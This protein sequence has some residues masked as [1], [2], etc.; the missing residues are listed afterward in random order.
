MPK[1]GIVN[2]ENLVDSS[3]RVPVSVD[4][5]SAT[6]IQIGAVEIKNAT[7]DTRATVGSNGLHVDVRN[8][9]ETIADD[10]AFTVATSKVAPAGFL[11]DE[12]ATD[13]VDEGDTGA[14]R[15]TL[16]RKVHVVNEFE[17]N[18]IRAS[19]TSLT[20][21]YAFANIAASTTDGAVVAAV[22]SKKI[23]VLGLIVMAGGTA[24]NIT[25]N[26]KP[27]GAGTAKTALFATG[28]NNGFG[29]GFNPVGWFETASGEGLSATTGTGS[30]VGVQVV[31]CE[32]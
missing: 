24:T 1:A 14:A 20:P 16:D 7:D 27:G 11:A 5:F 8:N 13:S 31:Y 25:F 32:V 10:A 3:G 2:I 4:N 29:M 26:T 23:R 17:S 6:D 9:A 22:A 30:T 19:G 18:S 12:T 21:K 28:A 15:M